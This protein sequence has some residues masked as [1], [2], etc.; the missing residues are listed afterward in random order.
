MSVELEMFDC[1]VVVHLC[2]TAFSLYKIFGL[3]SEIN[4]DLNIQY[5]TIQ[6]I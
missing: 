1:S 4:L 6:I 5:G 2:Y 3:M